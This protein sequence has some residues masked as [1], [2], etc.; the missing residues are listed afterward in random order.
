M[1]DREGIIWR[2]RIRNYLLLEGPAK[3][4]CECFSL[5]V[6]IVEEEKDSLPACELCSACVHRELLWELLFSHTA[7]EQIMQNPLCLV[8]LLRVMGRTRTEC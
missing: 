2:V 3:S 4:I 8:C 6:C 1:R 7:S 5:P